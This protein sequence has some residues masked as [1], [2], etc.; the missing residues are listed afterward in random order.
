[1]TKFII[2][3]G[4]IAGLAAA[5]AVARAGHEAEVLEQAS[6]FEEVGAGIQIGPN[7]RRALEAL[8]A[9]Q[10]LAPR[11]VFP[12]AIRIRRGSGRR[13]GELPLGEGFRSRFGGT[14]QVVHRADL[15]RALL[16][17]ARRHP[18]ID[19]KPSQQVSA[20]RLEAGTAT[21]LTE[22]GEAHE[23]HV[24]IGADGIRSRIRAQL[25]D[26]GPPAFAGHVLYRALVDAAR[27]PAEVDRDNVTLW[28]HDGGHV[29]HYPVSAGEKFNIVVAVNE[30]W[31]GEG[32]SE[33][34]R[35]E[36]L[37][38]IFA[39]AAQELR[40]VLALPDR[41]LRWAGCDR[42]PVSTWGTGRMTL[43]GDAAHPTL[44][45]LASGAVMA[46]EDAVTL[47]HMLP[48]AAD[49]PQATLRAWERSRQPRTARIV[50]SSHKLAEVYHAGWPLSFFRDQFIRLS[51][52]R[53]G[54]K[55][56]DWLYSWR[57]R[58]AGE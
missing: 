35:G 11:A 54:W 58:G 48:A 30:D 40:A 13:L 46:L 26:D 31:N 25:L 38:R 20:Y 19:L 27:V 24:L 28:L 6:A 23:G 2:A 16:E 42:E 29:V 55:R 57:P 15:L 34:S 43:I 33:P 36:I 21:A 5:I 22:N 1:M 12:R 53:R 44:P 3:G 49:A 10:A 17:T 56:M 50:S 39:D 18:A 45:Y 51:S 8:G 14:Y 41:W 7:G 9:W 52:G 4:G 37:Q 47:G 32:W